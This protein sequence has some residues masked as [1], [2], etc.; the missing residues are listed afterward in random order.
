MKLGRL[1]TRRR[2]RW[3]LTLLSVC[4][5]SLWFASERTFTHISRTGPYG[6]DEIEIYNGEVRL[7]H[8]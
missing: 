8:W 1:I 7:E 3:T 2:L 5:G 6:G 4:I